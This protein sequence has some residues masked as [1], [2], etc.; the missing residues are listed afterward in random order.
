MPSHLLGACQRA[1]C[2]KV[3]FA[4]GLFLKPNARWDGDR[5]FEFTISGRSDSDYAKCPTTKRSVSGYSA[6]MNGAP[7]TR[8]SKMQEFITLS[9]TEAEAVSAT[10]CAQDMLFGMRLL[11]SMGLKVKKPM[12]LE[13]D[14]KGAVDIFN[15]WSVSGRSRAVSVR[16][17]F[18]RELKESGTIEVKWISTV[19]NSTDLYTKNLD[20]KTFE[21]HTRNY[22]G[23]DEYMMGIDVPHEEGV[24]G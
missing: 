19:E 3:P 13:M 1:I 21:K 17:C 6:Y 12:F 14:N 24:R 18:L 11:E 10:A 2:L 23:S 9:V 15:N 4:S 7:Y 16:Y 8:K 5:N 22:C 20:Y